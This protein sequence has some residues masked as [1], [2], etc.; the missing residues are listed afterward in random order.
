MI[1]GNYPLINRISFKAATLLVLLVLI[2][3]IIP[4]IY[5]HF[6]IGVIGSDEC[7]HNEKSRSIML[8]PFI[9]G[10]AISI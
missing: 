7:D 4:S 10:N 2:V 3:E 1:K 5:V 8:S 6:F 9:T